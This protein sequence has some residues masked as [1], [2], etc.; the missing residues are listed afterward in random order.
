MKPLATIHVLPDLPAPLAPLW[1]LSYNLWWSWSTEVLELFFDIDPEVWFESGRNPL[2]FLASLS[3]D[4]L[5]AADANGELAARIARLTS[6][7]EEYVSRKTWFDERYGENGLQIAYFSLEFGIARSLPI[8]SG[9]LGVLAGDHLKSASNL[10]LPLAGV[11][12]LYR[13]GYFRQTLNPDGWQLETYPENDFDR[14]PVQPVTDSSGAALTVEVPYPHGAVAARIWRADV[15]REGLGPHPGAAPRA[16]TR[17]P[18]RPRQR[19]LHDRARPEAVRPGQRRQ[20]AARGGGAVDVG[21]PVARPRPFRGTDR[22]DC[23]RGAQPDLGVPADGWAARPRGRVSAWRFSPDC[24]KDMEAVRRIPD[25]ELWQIRQVRRQR[26]LDFTRR[27]LRSQFRRQGVPP[28]KA[29]RSLQRLDDSVFT[30]GFARRFATYKRGTL[31]LRNPDRLAALMESDRQPLQVLFAG[32]AHPHDHAGKELIRDIVA[33][34]RQEPFAG[35]LFFL[36]DYDINIARF[37]FQGC[38]VWLNNPRRPQE[39]S[40]TSGMKAAINGTLNI[41]VLDGWWEEACELHPGWVIGR[42]E[43]Y[44]DADYK[45]E[46]ESNALYDLLETEV[47]PLFYSRSQDGMPHGWIERIK[48]SLATLV[49]QYNTNRMVRE[50]LEDL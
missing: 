50:Y 33:L 27:H 5:A 10:G 13:Q 36:E 7:F 19:F 41:S 22:G 42:G 38:D 17:R 26:L 49:P 23:Q 29:E 12:L 32:K 43:V 8:Y 40:G 6:A 25:G 30:L 39:A 35:R 16:R 45:D 3:Q 48:E 34:S 1:D 31:L 2:R 46:V 14:L 28:A 4:R 37:M 9:G 18:R 15:D 20:P 24:G 11:G 21:S 47:I 44:E